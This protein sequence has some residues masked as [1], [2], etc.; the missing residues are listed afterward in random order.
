M[1]NRVIGEPSAATRK[2]RDRSTTRWGLVVARIPASNVSVCA[3]VIGNESV[4]FHLPQT[5]PDPPHTKRYD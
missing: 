3:P 4:G 2:I 5:I 1:S